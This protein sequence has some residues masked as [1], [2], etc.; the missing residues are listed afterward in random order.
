M[1]LIF[2]IVGNIASDIVNTI[3]NTAGPMIDDRVIN[4]I[5][6]ASG[7][8][9]LI[10]TEAVPKDFGKPVATSAT[11]SVNHFLP[12]AVIREFRYELQNHLPSLQL[13][14]SHLF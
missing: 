13:F 14:R 9:R 5:N 12:F 3:I 4:C 6:L 1:P 8:N 2:L 10:E 11:E 7:V